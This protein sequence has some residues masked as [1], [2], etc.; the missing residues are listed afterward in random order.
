LRH[1]PRCGRDAAE[2]Q[3]KHG[4]EVRLRH[5]PRADHVDRLR[6]D[7]GEQA[8]GEADGGVSFS[9][10]LRRVGQFACSQLVV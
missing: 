6:R 8:G 7:G 2:I 9:A 5:Q 1:L 3:P 4:G 10:E